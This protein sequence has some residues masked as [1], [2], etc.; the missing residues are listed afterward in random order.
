[1]EKVQLEY[2]GFWAR[3]VAIFIDAVL[4][5]VIEFPLL[6]AFYGSAYFTVDS[7]VQGPVDFMLDFVF[8]TV[9][10]I[11]FW[12]W[13]QAT[14]GKMALSAKIVDAETGK[15]PSIGQYIG[16]YFA[17]IISAIP[18]CLGFIWVAFDSKKQG[19]HDKLA[20][21]VVVRPK[22]TTEEVKFGC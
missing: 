19:W 1:M 4:L 9:A 2:V 16:R 11:L 14:P 10:T 18:F 20:G 6:L 12:F 8:P 17:Y 5:M 22:I 21:T 15:E 7:G 3:V 13:K